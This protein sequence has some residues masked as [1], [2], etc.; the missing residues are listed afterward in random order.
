MVK[1][2]A[3]DLNVRANITRQTIHGIPQLYLR[4]LAVSQLRLK[5]R[6]V[7]CTP[8]GTNCFALTDCFSSGEIRCVR[9]HHI[10]LQHFQLVLRYSPTV[11]SIEMYNGQRHPPHAPVFALPKLGQ[12]TVV[13]RNANLSSVRDSSWENESDFRNYWLSTHGINL[14]QDVGGYAMVRFFPKAAPMLYPACCLLTKNTI[15]H[16]AVRSQGQ[17]IK[18]DFIQIIMQAFSACN[19]TETIEAATTDSMASTHVAKAARLK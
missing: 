14:A 16:Q 17:A 12:A 5:L 8:F 10:Q 7:H 2:M 1:Q 18:N 19:V 3:R 4:D 6:S 9:L 11:Y 13:A 15:C